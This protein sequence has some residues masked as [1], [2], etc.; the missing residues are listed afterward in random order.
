MSAKPEELDSARAAQTLDATC[1]A[2]VVS[3]TEEVLAEAEKLLASQD[4]NDH[5]E[6]PVANQ[7]PKENPIE[8]Y[9]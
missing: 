9:E 5:A 4:L 8:N 1:Q 7:T 3:K 6:K 2:D